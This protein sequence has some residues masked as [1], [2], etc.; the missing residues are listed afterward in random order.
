MVGRRSPRRTILFLQKLL[1]SI[2]RVALFSWWLIANWFISFLNTQLLK[3]LQ[4]HQQLLILVW[5]IGASLVR[6]KKSLLGSLFSQG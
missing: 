1:V 6:K 2:W 5:L 4:F 3:S